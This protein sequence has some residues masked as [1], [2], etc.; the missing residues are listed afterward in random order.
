MHNE[1]GDHV[2]ATVGGIIG[3]AT[4]YGDSIQDS[5]EAAYAIAEKIKVP[6]KQMRSDLVECFQKKH[7]RVARMLGE[8]V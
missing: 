7:R 8:L 5:L 4:G 2:T 6:D 1:A 3:V